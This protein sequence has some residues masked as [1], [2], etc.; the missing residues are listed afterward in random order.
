MPPIYS[1]QYEADSFQQYA[2]ANRQSL[3][4]RWWAETAIVLLMTEPPDRQNEK[5]IL[6]GYPTLGQHLD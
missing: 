6:L 1:T 3:Q 4:F 5:P 2:D